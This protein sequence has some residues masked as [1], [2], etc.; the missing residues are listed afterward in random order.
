MRATSVRI[1]DKTNKQEDYQFI[2]KDFEGK[3]VIGW[4]VI[5][6]PWYSPGTEWTYWMYSNR[7]GSGGICGGASDFG[8]ERVPVNPETIR[9]YNQIEQIKYDLECGMDVRL[10]K[11]F[12]LFDEDAPKDNILAIIHNVNEIPYELWE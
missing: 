12:Y 1:F 5:E 4:I 2:A 7:Y 11:K 6:E 8:L 3:S 10:E 9:P